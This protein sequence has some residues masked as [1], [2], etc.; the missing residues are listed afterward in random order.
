MMPKDLYSY[1]RSSVSVSRTPS[2]RPQR[3]E[4]KRKKE[5]DSRRNSS[6]SALSIRTKDSSIASV[7]EHPSSPSPSPFP[8]QR[9]QPHS[10]SV[11]SFLLSHFP[12]RPAARPR[13]NPVDSDA[14]PRR[15]WEWCWPSVH[16]AVVA[17][18]SGENRMQEDDDGVLKRM[19]MRVSRGMAK[20]TKSCTK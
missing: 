2:A 1:S 11:H 10:P 7:Q 19:E 14:D 4:K 16:V 5:R 17:N 20:R 12:E 6:A 9:Q 13:S 18:D 8:H 3:E 15:R